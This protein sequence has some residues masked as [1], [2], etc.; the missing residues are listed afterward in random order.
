MIN[1]LLILILCVICIGVGVV[2]SQNFISLL[3]Q[4][5]EYTV[6]DRIT[7]DLEI[8]FLKMM[9]MTSSYEFKDFN[10]VLLVTSE[11][12]SNKI[13]CVIIVSENI[14]LKGLKTMNVI[15]D[16]LEDTFNTLKKYSK[17][18]LQD[19]E[20]EIMYDEHKQGET[21]GE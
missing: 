7:H 12:G 8:H 14:T 17:L 9:V 19:L 20:I 21:N 5:I 6:F 13:T 16:S 4:P 10:P 2:S 3:D 18:D 15:S 11:K 1:K